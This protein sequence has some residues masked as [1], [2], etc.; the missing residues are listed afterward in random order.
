MTALIV[1]SKSTLKYA[2]EME[3]KV[4]QVTQPPT[5]ETLI[6][7]VP[8]DEIIAIGGGSVIDTAK[9]LA[10]TS[11]IE[12][13]LAYPTTGAGASET[14]HAVYWDKG[15]KY[16]VHTPKP[17]TIINKDFTK[18]LPESIEI[19]SGCD[20]FAHAC[21]SIASVKATTISIELAKAA[22]AELETCKSGVLAGK[23]IEITGTNVGHALSYPLTGHYG[24]PHGWA[25]GIMRS[26]SVVEVPDKDYDFD[27]LV[28]EALSYPQI[29]ETDF[30]AT[31]ESVRGLY[32]EALCQ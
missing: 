26:G 3:G 1:C 5:E 10:A 4:Y 2:K 30:K 11:D 23:A 14:S 22:L 21:E 25:V 7:F 16:T 19:G 17:I 15:R 9:I 28:S 13:V 12:R 27:L 29:H 31:R 8:V 20:A 6:V 24:I 32:K 18:G